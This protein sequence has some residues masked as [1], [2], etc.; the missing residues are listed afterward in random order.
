MALSHPPITV[1]DEND[2]V[3][4]EATMAEMLEKELIHRL[5]R[6]MVEDPQGNIL[7][8]KRVADSWVYPGCWDVSAGGHVDS[9]ESYYNAAA[10]ELAEEI[11]LNKVEL[12]RLGR[13]YHE[14]TLEIGTFKRFIEVY[15]TKVP[16]DTVFNV[17]PD[18]VE[19]VRWFSLTE[20]KKLVAEHPEQFTDGVPD[21][22]ERYY[23]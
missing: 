10:R 8:Q 9:G 19:L 13:Y 3:V 11:G 6:V 2:N 21:A 1:V 18:E 23:S 7:L 5:A 12:E 15:R 22:F 17:Q 16:R 20:A 14:A 4:G